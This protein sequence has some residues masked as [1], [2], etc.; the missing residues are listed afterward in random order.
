[1]RPTRL[2]SLVLLVAL[3]ATPRASAQGTD[4]FTELDPIQTS[5]TVLRRAL[6]PSGAPALLE[7]FDDRDVP[8]IEPLLLAQLEH[9][10]P[11]MRTT[12]ATRLVRRGRAPVEILAR[13]QTADERSAVV[14]DMLAQEALSPDVAASLLNVVEL[15]EFARVVLLLQAR[16]A[17]LRDRLLEI[18][19]DENLAPVARGL[20][21][22][23][24]TELGTPSIQAWIESLDAPSDAARDRAIFDVIAAVDALELSEA[25]RD[26]DRIL[27]ARPADDALR[28][29]V[30]IALFEVAPVDGMD[31]WRRLADATTARDLVPVGFLLINADQPCPKTFLDRLTSEDRMQVAI[32]NLLAADPG[33][34]VEVASP[35]IALGHPATLRWLGDRDPTSLPTET[36]VPFLEIAAER[37]TG[38]R[39][40]AA[41]EMASA[42]ADRD[43][44]RFSVLLEGAADDPV[45]L[46]VLLRGVIGAS[47]AGTAALAR[48]S[49]EDP[50]RGLRSIALVAVAL[51]GEPTPQE[52]KRLVKLAGGGGGL[53]TDLRP[54][55]AWYH[56]A[57]EDAIATQLPI[58][59]AP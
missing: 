37:P 23:G 12:A 41:V 24:L 14:V 34:R 20:A 30:V 49:L 42:L 56:L 3:V 11:L 21:A 27:R 45:L 59:T 7:R 22:S 52:W 46:E 48:P 58:I 39:I 55:A 1:M 13:L 6:G 4:P 8:G 31:A 26:F 51:R 50:N 18:E 17:D 44:E 57:A 25:L 29:A 10:S 2:S 15:S 38:P 5:T 28:A 43:A 33:T 40:A 36:I 19:R 35:L 9:P 32:R 54:I 16:P 47:E 53:P